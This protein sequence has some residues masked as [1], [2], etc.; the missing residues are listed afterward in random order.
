MPAFDEDKPTGTDFRY[1]TCSQ[2]T[3]KLEIIPQEDLLRLQRLP[4]D[5]KI[6][7]VRKRGE[8]PRRTPEYERAAGHA[9]PELDAA[10]AAAA[11]A[12]DPPLIPDLRVVQSSSSSRVELKGYAINT[13]CDF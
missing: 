8:V 13:R 12:A 6:L 1:K 7:P 2:C 9:P 5:L 11:A 10:A 3:E 4:D